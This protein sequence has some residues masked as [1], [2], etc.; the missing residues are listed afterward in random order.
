MHYD[1]SK[2]SVLCFTCSKASALGLLNKAKHIEKGYC[3]WKKAGGKCGI[4]QT[5]NDSKCHAFAVQALHHRQLSTPVSG[6]LSRQLFAEQVNAQKCLH[7]IFTSIVY[8]ARQGLALRGHNEGEGNF[9]QLLKS[10][11]HDVPEMA[12][13]LNKRANNFTHHAVQDEILH[14]H[15]DAALRIILS[16]VRKSQSFAVIVDG[17]Q[18]ICRQEQESICMRYVDEQLWPHEEF[19]GFYAVD[20][21]TGDRL[22][23]CIKDCLTRYQLPLERLRG[24]TYDGASN[25]SG[26]YNGCQTI[27]AREQPL[28]SYVHCSAHCTNLIAAAVCS[29]STLVRD[30]VQTVNDFGVLCSA[31]GKFKALLIKTADEREEENDSPVAPGPVRIIKPLCPTRWLVRVPAVNAAVKQYSLIMTTLEGAQQTCSTEVAARAVSF[32]HRFENPA[33][34]LCLQLAQHVLEPLESLNKSLQSTTMTVAWMLEA[35]AAV[36]SQYENMREDDE[37]DKIWESFEANRKKLALEELGLSRTRKPP[38]R[39]CGDGEAF[40]A[41]TV[42]QHYRIEFRKIIDVAIQQLNQR[43]LQCPGLSSYCELESMLV[44]GKVDEKIAYRYPELVS[45]GPSFQTQLDMFHMVLSGMSTRE[46]IKTVVTL[47]KCA[48]V[49]RDMA[50]PMRA[51]FPLVES[52]IRLLLVNPASSAT[53]ERSFSSLRRLKTYLRSTCGQRR[54]NDIALCHIH[55]DIVDKVD[56]NEVMKQFIHARDSRVIAFGHV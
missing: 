26:V 8:L 28:A 18:D 24:Q 17:S 44:S 55:K 46:S 52:L 42:K 23:K 12:Q 11:S 19:V 21:T 48:T 33:T 10:R 20:E 31:S 27:L 36:K 25:M 15:A 5:H 7:V 45:E 40:R 13:W 49:L 56:T 53:A 50:P 32:L 6:L 41:T 16:Q 43:L 51:M 39:F 47:D 54:L 34:L 14:L 22:A 4:F 2:K 9:S 35:A 29:S 1:T 3:N 38:V 30:A 37:F